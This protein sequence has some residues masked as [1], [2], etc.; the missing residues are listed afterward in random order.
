MNR[1]A[2]KRVDGCGSDGGGYGRSMSNKAGMESA[3]DGSLAIHD[4]KRL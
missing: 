3:L 4:W 2:D 1:R